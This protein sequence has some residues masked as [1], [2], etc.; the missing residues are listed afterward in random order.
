MTGPTGADGALNAWGLTGNSGTTAGTNF[1]GTIDSKDLVI[2]TNSVERAR[3]TVA[4]EI[5]VGD[6]TAAGN[7]TI[8]IT[9][10]NLSGGAV[11]AGDIVVVSTTTDNAFSTTQNTA[12]YSVLGVV[13]QGVASGA[14]GKVAISGVVTVNIDGASTVARGQH[15]ITGST[16]GKASGVAIPSA[17]TSIGVYLTTGSPGGTARVLLK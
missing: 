3:V 5:S 4:G 14:L 16:F 10:T 9:L 8:V 7:N 12:S 6:G 15:C 13:T 2:K 17:G 1:L 11:S